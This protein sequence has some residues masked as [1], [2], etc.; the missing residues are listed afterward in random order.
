MEFSASHR[1]QSPLAVVAAA[2]LDPAAHVGRY[3]LMGSRDIEVLRAATD[4]G[5]LELSTVRTVEGDVPK[6]AQKVISA[7]NTITTTERWDHVGDRLVGHATI[8]ASSVPGTATIAAE[9]VAA[10]DDACTFTIELALT[11]KVPLIGERFVKL[12]RPQVMEIIEAEFD[13]WDR[14]FAR[15]VVP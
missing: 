13:A 2:F 11:M 6:V 10:G 9:V 3:E 12:L 8:E 14:W 1:L 4:A 7:T 5:Q 15:S